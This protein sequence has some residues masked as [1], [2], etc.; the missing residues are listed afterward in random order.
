MISEFNLN[1][2]N[3]KVE[4][5]ISNNA[6]DF[7]ISKVFKNHIK[8]YK[9]SIDIVLDTTGGKDFF[10]KNTKHTDKF[11]TSLYKY[12][13]RKHFGSYQPMSTAIPITLVALGSYG[14]EQLCI[15]SD[16]DLMILYED[17]KGYNLKEIMEDF[18]TLA[19]DCGLKLGS[20]VHEL[21]EIEDAVKED[22]TIKTSII[23]SRVICGSKYLWFAYENTLNNIRKTDIEDFVIEKL[24]EHKQRLLKY[25]LKMEPN[26][27]DGYGGLRESNMISWMSYILYGTQNTKDLIGKEITEEEHKIYRSSLEYIFQVRNAL[28]NISKRKLD[29]V[30]FDVLPELSSK[31]GFINKPR[32][33]KERQCMSKL[34]YSLHNIHFFSTVMVKKF[35]RVLLKQNTELKLLKSTRLKKNLYLF[36]GKVYTSF[37]RKP[38]SLNLFLKELISLPK[39]VKSFDRSYIYYASKIKV[40]TKQTNEL[41]KNIKTLLLKT[42]LYPIIKLLYNSNLFQTIIPITKKIINQPQFDGYHQHPVDIHSIKTLKKIE[43]IE[44]TFIKEIYDSLTPSEK[45]VTK[46]AALL[47]DVG[48]GRTGDHHI[49]GEKLSKN[50]MLSLDFD[51]KQV[52][53]GSQLVRYHNKMSAYAKNEDIYSERI[54]LAFTGIV[55]SRQMLKMLYIVTYADISA[56]GKNVFNSS[57]ASL[58]K[59]LYF[60]SLPAFENLELLKESSRRVA[61]INTIKNL[62][63]Y[64]EL[65]N[66]MKRKIKYISSNQI[67]LRLKAEDILD[68]AIK[69]KDVNSYIYKITNN[70][71]LV[72]RIIRKIPLN[73]GFLLGKLEFLNIF[74]MNIFKLYDEKKAFEITFSEKVDQGDIEL[75]KQIIE[76]SFDMSKITK[77]RKPVIKKNEVIANCNHSPYLAS[78]Q[79]K[80]KDQKGLFAYIAKIFDDFNIE[81]ESAKLAS[82]KNYTRDLILIEKNG[83]FCGKQ[84]EIIN[85]ICSN[86]D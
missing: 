78:L 26:I 25:P 68:I 70:Q 30:N 86:E 73:L 65:S 85:L 56:V 67:F 52:Q 79:V 7:E 4:E 35:A 71:Q 76:S 17:I 74:S 31:L 66:L 36:E 63:R 48:K 27:K 29:V 32:Y 14:R 9:K 22:I 18:I 44:D 82:T 59:E 42:S 11:L 12:I 75:V 55:K 10:V 81:I 20:R 38:I 53:M 51:S 50:F 39:E 43:N 6:S 49:A 41:K 57:T 13:L 54:I 77:T 58:L 72:I 61:K 2:V 80:T 40:P 8:E 37:H 23:E 47:H 64:K 83:T 5:L 28:H 62:K 19:W 21:N 45:S 24:E 16:I 69:A 33:T 1:E 15:Y 3:L 34:L 60:Q 84:D 46:L